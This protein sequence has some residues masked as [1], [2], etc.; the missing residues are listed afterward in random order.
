MSAGI[1]RTQ[2]K[3]CVET[4]TRHTVFVI[5]MAWLIHVVT[6]NQVT[7]SS[8]HRKPSDNLL[9]IDNS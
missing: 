1:K 6:E 5:M 8:R 3:C 4:H 7:I 2:L 9:V